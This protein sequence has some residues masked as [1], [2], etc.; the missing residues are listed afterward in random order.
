MMGP[1]KEK[2][3][4]SESLRDYEFADFPRVVLPAKIN[5]RQFFR[6]LIN[7]LRAAGVNEEAH[8]AFRLCDLGTL[9]DSHLAKV[10]P[11]L[12]PG[13]QTTARGGFI[14]GMTPG[15]SEA[16]RLFP[17]GAPAARVLGY[18]DGARTI[19]SMAGD[20]AL[21]TGWEKDHA[22]AYIRGVFLWLVT[23]RMAAPR[24]SKCA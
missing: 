20:L 4:K 5:R 10:V 8:P 9:P 19:A 12:L 21:E 7:D 24:D 11:V 2:I 14:W 23:A 13:C 15:E 22:F 3:W 1:G 6:D 17:E 16:V 18:F